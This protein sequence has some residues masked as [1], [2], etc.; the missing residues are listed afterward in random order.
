MLLATVFAW[1]GAIAVFGYLAPILF[2]T[3]FFRVQN[4]K[5]KYN[6]EWALVT[7]N[8]HRGSSG[9]GLALS[10]TLASQGISVVVAA[11]DDKMMASAKASLPSKYPKVKFRFVP[12]NLGATDAKVYMD[13]IIEATKDIP[14]TL[15]FNNAGYIL[16]GLFHLT[17]LAAAVSNVNVSN[18]APLNIT[19]HFAGRMVAAKQRG[20]ICFTSSPGGFM[21]SPMATLY[22]STKAFL[23]NFGAS[24]AGELAPNGIDVCVVHPSPT[25]TGF[26]NGVGLLSALKMFQ[27]TSVQPQDIADT[28]F[29]CVGR[30]VCA[31]HGYYTVLNR[32]LL[33]LIDYTVMSDL[34]FAFVRTQ[35]D[36][37][38]IKSDQE[39]KLAAKV[40]NT[41]GSCAATPDSQGISAGIIQ[42]T[43]CSGNVQAVCNDY[44]NSFCDKYKSSLKAATGASYCGSGGNSLT[45]DMS[46]YGLGH[47]CSDW[48]AAANDQRFQSVQINHALAGF[49]NPLLPTFQQ[50]GITA[51]ALMAQMYDAS[52]Q[53]GP[54]GSIEIAK[55]ATYSA[56]GSPRAGV[57]QGR[58]LK[59]FLNARLA[60]NS[61]LGGAYLGTAYRVKSFQAIWAS[62][63]LNFANNKHASVLSVTSTGAAWPSWLPTMH[64]DPDSQADQQATTDKINLG[65]TKSHFPP[66]REI[67]E[68]ALKSNEKDDSSHRMNE[69][70]EKAFFLTFLPTVYAALAT[71]KAFG[72]PSNRSVYFRGFL[73]DGVE[74]IF[75]DEQNS[76]KHRNQL[77]QTPLTPKELEHLS[78]VLVFAVDVRSGSVED[79]IHGSKFG[80]ICWIFPDTREQLRLSGQLHLLVS[81]TH[82]LATTHQLTSPFACT[83]Q[84]PHL[85]WETVRKDMWRR[86]SSV[87]R[88]SYTWPTTHHEHHHQ[89]APP[90]VH[91]N[92][93]P[94]TGTG[95]HDSNGP[96]KGM[97]GGAVATLAS[98]SPE[99]LPIV[100]QI[101]VS[102]VEVD[103]PAVSAEKVNKDANDG[104][105]TDVSAVSSHERKHSHKKASD[106]HRE[107][108]FNNFCL[109][110][111]DVDG[112]DHLQ[113]QK[114]PHAHTKY[115]R[116]VEA[117]EKSD[118]CAK[119]GST[120]CVERVSVHSQSFSINDL[121]EGT[122]SGHGVEGLVKETAN[123]SIRN[124][125]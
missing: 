77:S 46:Q 82:H 48:M 42:F 87:R 69:V 90:R 66:W 94:T 78:N 1:I 76:R 86:I 79:L 58:W 89:H 122:D 20:C 99:T 120:C 49:F 45:I 11:L 67:L 27:K 81:P 80:E 17:P 18:M 52:V 73:S 14:V 53:Y 103:R 16:V 50:L 64:M 123:W 10:E 32:L 61:H 38:N 30:T 63:D 116:S 68:N 55:D 102:D 43:T 108:A 29:R 41:F 111:L 104:S 115:R 106:H 34:M 57:P 25:D 124:V 95:A 44:P 39:K 125:S 54:D 92:H 75:S 109:L 51:P 71:I 8:E 37:V 110:L 26:Y 72:R 56:G 5:K 62:N 70:L 24:I 28:L 59:A 9:I 65:T 15:V 113:M 97:V 19:H 114:A 118:A 2:Q 35:K 101:D 40:S 85:D 105:S 107:V 100:T 60:Y 22:S 36:F 84:F 98:S 13:P 7:G 3:L 4:L 21:P 119:E 47:F 33:K 91:R 74:S 6:A 12:V 96:V 83:P 93:M 112:V 23:T 31:E 121:I 88:A 117:V